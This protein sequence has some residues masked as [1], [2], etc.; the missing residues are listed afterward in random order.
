MEIR[1][2]CE[3]ILPRLEHLEL[4]SPPERLASTFVG[5]IKHLPIRFRMR[6]A[7]AALR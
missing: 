7:N 5:G 4:A 6:D 2:F 3:E 1:I